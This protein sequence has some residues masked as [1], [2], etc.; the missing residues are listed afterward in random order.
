MTLFPKRLTLLLVLLAVAAGL[1]ANCVR[2]PSPVTETW[3][4]PASTQVVEAAGTR[5]PAIAAPN[6]P[7]PTRTAVPAPTKTP[8]PAATLDPHLIVITEDDITKAIAGGAGAQQGAT[9]HN[10]KVRFADSKT[11]ITADSI[12]YGFIQMQN[13]D[14]LGRLVANDG[15]LSLAVE[16][17]S[18][19]GLAAG[20]IPSVTNQAL[21]QYA[22]QWYVE[23]VRTLDGRLELRIR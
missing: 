2:L 16:S 18:P 19:G 1:L 17:V 21:A 7:R 12:G 9:L 22:S 8:V 23:E 11:R 5:A 10:L 15:V 4:P 13:L 14:L 6:T 20:F 3:S